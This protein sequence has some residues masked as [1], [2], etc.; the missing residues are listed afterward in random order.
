ML[1]F[2][3]NYRK[4]EIKLHLPTFNM[5]SKLMELLHYT[6]MVILQVF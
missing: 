6:F 5:D 3:D 1:I 2:L 4:T